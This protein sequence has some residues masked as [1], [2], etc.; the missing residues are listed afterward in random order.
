M[1]VNTDVW[2]LGYKLTS[3]SKFYEVGQQLMFMFHMKAR[4]TLVTNFLGES[5]ALKCFHKVH[6]LVCSR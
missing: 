5:L 4:I 3:P 6:G 1:T 2:S